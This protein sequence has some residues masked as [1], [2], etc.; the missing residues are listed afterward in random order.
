MER[1]EGM[2]WYDGEGEVMCCVRGEERRG[3]VVTPLEG[4]RAEVEGS[5]RVWFVSVRWLHG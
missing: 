1:N 3:E 4:S 5:C 2:G